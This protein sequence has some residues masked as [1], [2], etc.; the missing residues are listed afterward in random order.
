M[1]LRALRLSAAVMVAASAIVLALAAGPAWAV[2]PRVEKA[3]KSD[4]KRLCPSYR[5]GS[6]SLKACMDAN[7]GSLSS[8][9]RDALIDSGEVDRY[10]AEQARRASR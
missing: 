2:S 6:T 1:A 3:C 7:Q 9:C 8:R 5:V 10:R 4:Y